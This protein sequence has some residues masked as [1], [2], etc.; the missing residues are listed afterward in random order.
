MPPG[1]APA[2]A[3]K[4]DAHTHLF[5][6]EQV[7]S[8]ADLAARDATFR[9]MYADPSAK[10]ATLPDL[11]RALDLAGFDGAIVAGFAFASAEDVATQNAALLAAVN[12]SRF[13]LAPFVTVN[14]MVSDWRRG[15][16]VAAAAGARG[17]GE[18]R[19]GNQGWDPLGREG[20][21]LCEAAAALDL[22][23]LWHAS[24]PVGHEYPGKAGGIDPVSLIR[25]AS[26]FPQ[27]PMIGAHLGAG[28]SFY[29]QMPEVREIVPMLFFDTA[30]AFL[31]YDDGCVAR[32][33]GQL[34][35]DRVLF[36]SDFPLLS[37]RRQAARV[38]ESL[39]GDSISGILGGNA[40]SLLFGN[41]RT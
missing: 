34:G 28:A 10:M 2:K 26:E 18:L 30:A 19:P 35:A 4:I 20:R 29:L 11:E 24:E 3:L 6:P 21:E 12:E 5:A 7:A 15:L 1:P 22:T 38:A 16:E 14:P 36:G 33:A 25:I 40:A 32:L 13:R 17:I 39:H 8:R 27:V 41:N 31:L 37:P 23:L 9:E